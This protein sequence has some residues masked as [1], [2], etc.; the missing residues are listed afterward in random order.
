[1][2]DMAEEGLVGL[3]DFGDV[4]EMFQFNF[5]RGIEPVWQPMEQG[6]LF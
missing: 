3:V 4:A 1:M 6:S 5:Q 2:A